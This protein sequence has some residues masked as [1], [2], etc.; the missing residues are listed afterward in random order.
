MAQNWNNILIYVK[1]NLGT[2][3]S[4]LEITDDEFILYFKEITLP[5]F[6]QIIPL[7]AWSVITSSDLI[8]ESKFKSKYTYKLNNVD[9]YEVI[10]VASV[11]LGHPT[12]AHVL[13]SINTRNP[14]DIV[15]ANTLNDM[16]KFLGTVNDYEF[17][18]PNYIRFTQRPGTDQFIAELNIEHKD[19]ITIPSDMYHK[20]FRQMCLVDALE[21]ILN[22]R[23]KFTNITTPFGEI[24]L[25]FD[26]IQQKAA[27]LRRQNEEMIDFLPHREYL[28]IF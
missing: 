9:E 3:T 6:S 4:D 12:A 25:N 23:N 5:Y 22:N 17:I 10:D 21:L 8:E 7:H 1:A 27:D 14:A 16:V 15:M 24:N 19:C 18:K 28:E 11:Y 20:L 13:S 2:K 26:Y